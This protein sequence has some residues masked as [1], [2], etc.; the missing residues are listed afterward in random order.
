MYK[1]YRYFFYREYLFAKT[2]ME[3]NLS[4]DN[5]HFEIMAFVN[6]SILMSLHIGL[7]ALAFDLHKI[8]GRSVFIQVHTC[9][10]CICC[11][12]NYFM[13]VKNKEFVEFEKRYSYETIKQK[14]IRGWY[15]FIL[16]LLS[17]ISFAYLL[18]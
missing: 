5:S 1:I 13:L 14:K 6:V 10:F 18:L 4:F 7:L 16:A 12:F 2:K 11:L 9:T 3:Q 17:L 8:I 15:L